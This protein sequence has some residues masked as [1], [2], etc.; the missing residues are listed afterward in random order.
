LV[1]VRHFA[2]QGESK[3]KQ[4]A[5]SV[6]DSDTLVDVGRQD[7]TEE[8]QK[9]LD[10]MNKKIQVL[11][12]YV[13]GVA[14][15]F[16]TGLFVFGPGGSSKSYTILETLD[17][18]GA[19]Y[20]LHNSRLTGQT[21][22]HVISQAPDS[23]HVLED[24]ETLFSQRNARGVLRS[25]LWGQHAD[26]GRGPMERWVTWGSTGKRPR[27]LRVLFTGG[28][29]MAANRDFDSSCPELTAVK[30]RIPYLMLAPSDAEVRALLRHLARRGW[31]ADG[32][33]LDPHE[34]QDVAEYLIRQC[35]VLRRRLDLRLLENAYSDFLLWREGHALCHWQDLLATRLRERTTYFRQEVEVAG[36][37]PTPGPAGLAEAARTRG[38]RRRAQHRQER[39]RIVREV[40]TTTDVPAEQYD[41]WAKLTGGASVAAFYRW[42][43][44]ALGTSE[45]YLDGQLL[46]SHFLISDEK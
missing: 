32:R 15:G 46:C 23:I 20:N 43:A 21:L 11:R 9:H 29:I 28:L 16:Y 8:D 42:S 22:F 45:S 41:L 35:S 5:K 3:M 37:T 12:D 19:N 6:L 40:L 31:D 2:T 10:A 30:T 36:P 44:E 39:L 24:M 7:L 27:E 1:G 26:G 34:C 18:V 13:I 14:R 25:A 4:R 17:A 33:H 38:A